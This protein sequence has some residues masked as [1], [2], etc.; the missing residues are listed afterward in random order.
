MKE[1][2][3][4]L[5]FEDN[6]DDLED[7]IESIKKHVSKF[8]SMDFTFDHFES[9]PDDFDVKMFEGKYTAAF[10][11]LNLNNGQ[12]G[13]DIVKILREKGAFIDIL[14]YSNNPL[15]LIKLTEGDNYIEGV[16]RF[17]TLQGI[18]KKITQVLDQVLYKELMTLERRK[19]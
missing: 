11:D 18:D 5:W 6:I 16:F 3:K 4:V 10:I 8:H 12:K 15:E 9:Y 14:L 19:K 1:Q 2:L 17:A 7:I 13:V